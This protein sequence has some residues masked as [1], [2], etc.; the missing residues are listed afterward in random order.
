MRIERAKQL[1]L[2]TSYNSEELAH[3]C[4]AHSVP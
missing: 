3:A 4:G 1:L 2:D